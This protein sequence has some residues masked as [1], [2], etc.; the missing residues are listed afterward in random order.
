MDSRTNARAGPSNYRQQAVP[1]PRLT[2]RGTHSRPNSNLNPNAVGRSRAIPAKPRSS[3][4]VEIPI[5]RRRKKPTTTFPPIV[6]EEDASSIKV[7]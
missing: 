5:G 3:V 2:A 7:S 6:K 1:E 4:V